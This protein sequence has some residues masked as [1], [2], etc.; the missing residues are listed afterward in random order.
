MYG[1]ASF[2]LL[3]KRL[4]IKPINHQKWGRTRLKRGAGDHV[5]RNVQ[6]VPFYSSLPKDAQEYGS[7]AKIGCDVFL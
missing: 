2:E 7:Y 5:W 1:R 6:L 3:R 4:V